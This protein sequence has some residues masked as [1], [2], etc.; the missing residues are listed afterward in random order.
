[1]ILYHYKA[2]LLRVIDGDTVKLDVDLGFR[3]HFIH[4][5]RLSGIN[6]PENDKPSTAFLANLLATET[7]WANAGADHTVTTTK[8][9]KYGRWLVTIPLLNGETANDRMIVAGHAA[10]YE[11]GKR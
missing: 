9:D 10:A 6:A 4:L 2:K 3:M 7:A 11:G 8:A 1:M 5:F